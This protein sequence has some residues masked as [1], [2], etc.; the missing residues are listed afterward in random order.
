MSGQ[1]DVHLEGEDVVDFPI[2]KLHIIVCP[3]GLQQLFLVIRHPAVY[4]AVA[5][6]GTHTLSHVT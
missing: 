5:Q 3:S 2:I 4:I 1:V 6:C